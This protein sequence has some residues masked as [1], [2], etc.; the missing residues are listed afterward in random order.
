MYKK[1]IIN[2]KETN[3]SISESGVIKN[4]ITG[5]EL[6]GTYLSCEYKKVTLVID[7]TFKTFLV[8]RL[9][10]ETFLNNPNN[11]P[12]VHHIDGNKLNNHVSNLKWVTYKENTE[13]GEKK[14]CGDKINIDE[15]NENWKTIP[16][17][18]DYM[19]SKNGEIY[20]KKRKRTLAGSYRNGYL[21]AL[22]KGKS[23]SFHIL[24][25][26]TFIG[27]IPKG[28]VLDHINGI[29]DDNRLVNLRC[30]TQSENMYNAQRNGHRGQK[31]IAQFDLQ[32]NF[33]KEY[34]SCTS[35]AKEMNVT[36]RAISSA[37]ERGGTS[38][39][40]FWEFV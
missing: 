6:E 40:Y 25:Y 16:Y 5:K 3:Y 22:I 28:Y 36:Y 12:V 39:G 17:L 31:R 23:Y 30:V 29:R 8:H 4:N 7:N 11:F 14:R 24:I 26:N 2:N 32:H 38:C 10:A 27:E 13:T 21:R 35:A 37:A 1:I 18:P 20:N 15:D 33:I 34:S 9:V 19:A